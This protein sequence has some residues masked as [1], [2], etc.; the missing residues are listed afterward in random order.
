VVEAL[1]ALSPKPTDS[2]THYFVRND[3]IV[4]TLGGAVK[5]DTLSQPLDSCG[6]L[7]RSEVSDEQDQ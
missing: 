2:T 1:Q 6:F 4:T 3:V 5:T 7:Q